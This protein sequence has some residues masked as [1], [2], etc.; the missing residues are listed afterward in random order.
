[1]GGWSKPCNLSCNALGRD[2]WPVMTPL[3]LLPPQSTSSCGICRATDIT[4]LPS[5]YRRLG[6]YRRSQKQGVSPPQAGNGRRL[7][8][9]ISLLSLKD[10][11][12]QSQ[13]W[14][15]FSAI[16]SLLTSHDKEES[17]S[18]G[19]FLYF[20]SGVGLRWLKSVL[21]K[22]SG[23]GFRLVILS[24]H[25]TSI[26]EI[27]ILPIHYIY[28]FHGMSSSIVTWFV[29]VAMCTEYPPPSSRA[30]KG[31]GRQKITYSDIFIRK[32]MCIMEE[33]LGISRKGMTAEIWTN[34]MIKS[35]H[36]SLLRTSTET[37]NTTS[38]P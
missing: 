23:R 12:E 19:R 10:G 13:I 6:Y 37:T 25:T 30:K 16:P 1:M 20:V 4:G 21:G 11:K 17:A 29:D 32:C 14:W 7:K 38:Q 35:R 15:D 3:L 9:I 26:V 24:C 2:H 5:K 33:F 22:S 36:F 34:D 18:C 31:K 27:N 28:K 8:T